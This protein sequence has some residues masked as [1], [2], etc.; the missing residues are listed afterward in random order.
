MLGGR[1][2]VMGI[3]RDITERKRAEEILR[4]DKS[5]LARLVERKSAE[6]VRAHDELNKAKRLSDIGMLAATVAHELRNPLAAIRIAIYNIKKKSDDP[7]LGSHLDN[8]EK[9]ILESDQ[10]IK[11]LLLYSS[12]KVPHRQAVVVSDLMEQSVTSLRSMFDEYKVSIKRFYKCPEGMT[13]EADPVQIKE[14]FN[15]L[16][17]NAYESF[18]LKKGRIDI[19][20][21]TEKEALKVRIADNGR[22]VPGTE[23]RKLFMPFFSTKAKGLGLG[24][25][26]CRQIIELHGG[27]IKIESRVGKG[28]TV[29]VRLPIARARNGASSS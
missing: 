26:L 11:N 15:N 21:W 5:E 12:V 23:L 22:G 3:F 24:L 13:I 2:C 1:A 20:I 10:I 19:S 9:K 4:R 28:T 7:R 25:P 27:S 16:L 17:S 29:T 8:M 14:V 6:L 18:G